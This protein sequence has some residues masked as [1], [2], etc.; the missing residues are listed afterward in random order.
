MAVAAVPAFAGDPC[1]QTAYGSHVV[2]TANDVR[3][4]FAENPR[5]L[6]GTPF[7]A[8]HGCT[9]GQMFS[10]VAD[11]HVTS[12]ATERSNIGL[13]FQTSGSGNAVTGAAGTCTDNIIAPPHLVT[14]DNQCL[15]SGATAA[16]AAGSCSGAGTYEELDTG[17]KNAALNEPYSI[18]GGTTGCGDISTSDNNQV[19]SVEVDNAKCVAGANGMLLLPNAVSWQQQGGTLFCTGTGAAYPWSE[20]KT[21]IPGSPSKCNE[22]DTFTVPIIVQSPTVSV[23]KTCDIGGGPLTSC[24]F[25]ATSE[26]GSVTY[27]V[28]V[29]N[30]SNTGSVTLEQ[31][32]DSYYGTIAKDASY[33]GAACPTGTALPSGSGSPACS[34][35]Q[36]LAPAGQSGATYTCQFTANQ[37][38]NLTV[39]DT[40]TAT[41]LGTDGKTTFSG[42]SGQVTVKSG[43]V[44][45]T[46]VINKTEVN[47]TSAC[48]TVR[49]KVDA[50]AT[51]DGPLTLTKLTDDSVDLTTLSSPIVGT[52]CGGGPQGTMAPICTAGTCTSGKVGSA[53]S[54]ASD[55]SLGLAGGSYGS[56]SVGGSDY[57]CYFD[58]SFCGNVGQISGTGGYSCS[59]GIQHKDTVDGTLTGDEGESVSV[60]DGTVTVNECITTTPQ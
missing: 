12:T 51:A 58:A 39:P 56:I 15:G 23:G 14:G 22:D 20:T 60:T 53:C 17:N 10:F 35:P 54:Q 41:V 9:A 36:T 42:T 37:G 31:I 50:S 28:T 44:A 8:T 45:G 30:T 1:V 13:Y 2:C 21:A 24:D 34:L 32:C 47:T 52:T 27:T 40:I 55:C 6:D 48:V 57:V 26:G 3:I 18:T 49:Y 46:A 38:E 7:D 29:T 25:G 5:H 4:A 59:S 33:G 16:Q 43:D 11:F 19:V